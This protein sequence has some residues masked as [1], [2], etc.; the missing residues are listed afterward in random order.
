MSRVGVDQ[1]KGSSG[2]PHAAPVSI[3]SPTEKMQCEGLCPKSRQEKTH[4]LPSTVSLP[5]DSINSA[6]CC[7][8]ERL[9]GSHF[10][11][12]MSPKDSF[13]TPHAWRWWAARSKHPTACINV[14][15]IKTEW[16]LNPH[17][18][19]VWQ[20][21]LLRR[22]EN[23]TMI[24]FLQRRVAITMRLMGVNFKHLKHCFLLHQQSD[25]LNSW[26]RPQLMT[27]PTVGPLLKQ[28]ASKYED[29]NEESCIH[30]EIDHF[31]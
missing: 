23:S 13:E 24:P 28:D 10:C 19:Q 29:G 1:F 31:L 7:T 8:H 18:I 11:P 20:T 21:L 3:A 15:L 12:W 25:L 16:P 4:V 27:G 6:L 26:L 17:E 22:W 9:R 30:F 14:A 5:I 2:C